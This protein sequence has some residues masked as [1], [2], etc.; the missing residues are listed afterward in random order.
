[1][2]KNKNGITLIAMVITIIVLLILAGVAISTL[3]G[4]NGVINRTTK[5]KTATRAGE[6][7]D[8]L[9]LEATNN[10]AA[11]YQNEKQKT[12]SEFI[13]E[14]VAEGKLSEEEVEELQSAATPTITIG[15]IALDFSILPESVQVW[16]QNGTSV[17]DGKIN[18][19]VGTQVTGYSVTGHTDLNWYVLGAKDGKLLITTNTNPEK[20]TLEGKEGF[21]GGVATLKSAAEK[22]TN[23]DFAEGKARSMEVEDINRV[24]GYDPDVAKINE[25]TNNVNQWE[26]EV[27]YT[28]KNEKIYYKGTKYPKST[29][30]KPDGEESTCLSFEYWNGSNWIKLGD[31][32]NPVYVSEPIKSTYYYYYPNTLTASSSGDTNGI[33]TDS[34]AYS[35]LFANTNPW[36]SAPKGS[37]WLSSPCVYC[38]GGCAD[39]GLRDVSMGRVDHG[40]TFDSRGGVYTPGNGLRPV[41]S[42]K[43]SVK[44]T[45]G[46]N[47]VVVSK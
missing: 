40:Y 8:L 5:A 29:V 9:R 33:A 45:N 37:Y 11:E 26:N 35:L 32:E 46:T 19:T 15:G 4:E 36:D 12:R 47:E 30:D 39:F 22:Y 16:T 27:T 28:L 6:I 21:T 38:N 10:K 25:G 41:V 34:P 2:L 42:L 23:A 14:L 17:T 18:L 3:A 13:T 20:F 43:S 1:M 24:T 7:K 31:G 44:V